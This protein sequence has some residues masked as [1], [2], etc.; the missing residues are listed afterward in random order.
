M[1]TPLPL[2]PLPAPTPPALSRQAFLLCLTVLAMLMWCTDFVPVLD[3]FNL[4]I[5]ESG[6]LLFA[7]LG[8]SM[9]L[10]GGTLM[11]FVFPLAVTWHF[12]RLQQPMSAAVGV[13]WGLEN[14]Q[15]VAFYL[16]DARAQ[17]LPLV[18]GGEHDWFNILSRWG[19]L[20]WDTRLA[21]LLNL[22]S[23]IGM[24]ALAW[25]AWSYGRPKPQRFTS[26]FR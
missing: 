3:H 10:Y 21:T 1:N 12:W 23:W 7:I 19:L 6:H 26:K 24:A 5:H 9:S 4:A 14:I 25:W 8:N 16:G 22:L 18:G 17:K 2:P 20:Q 15:Y 13:A 11:Q